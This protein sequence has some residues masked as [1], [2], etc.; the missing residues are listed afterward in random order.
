MRKQDPRMLIGAQVLV[1]TT[2]EGRV[3]KVVGIQKSRGSSTKH[4]IVFDGGNGKPES[5]L[6]QKGTNAK[7]YKFHV[8][9]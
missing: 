5:V 6:L 4:N 3:G 9:E 7:G 8:L 2:E 1:F